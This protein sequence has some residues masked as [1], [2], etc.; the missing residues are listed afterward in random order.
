MTKQR[1]DPFRLARSFQAQGKCASEIQQGL[2][3]AGL[4]REAAT[5]VLETLLK[6]RVPTR[7]P[8]RLVLPFAMLVACA[9]LAV[10]A[11]NSFRC[12]DFGTAGLKLG[13]CLGVLGGGLFAVSTLRRS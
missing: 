11:W 10:G 8:S 13:G 4:Q 5:Q 6:R 2:I 1:L 7:R 12:G 9:L 3:D